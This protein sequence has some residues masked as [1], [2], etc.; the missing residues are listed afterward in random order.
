MYLVGQWRGRDCE[1]QPG[2]GR[3]PGRVL[4]HGAAWLHGYL[5]SAVKREAGQLQGDLVAEGERH[6]RAEGEAVHA[7][8]RAASRR[9]QL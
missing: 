6:G 2:G 3:N 4:R 9:R 1:G 7:G 8:C 5:T